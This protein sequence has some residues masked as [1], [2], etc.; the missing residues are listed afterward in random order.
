MMAP[1]PTRRSLLVSAASAGGALA[2]GAGVASLQAAESSPSGSGL[3]T[4]ASSLG[5]SFGCAVRLDQLNSDGDLRAAV[6]AQCGELT[7]EIG[8][9]WAVIEPR[10][11]ALDLAEM[12]DL[13]AFS[14]RHGLRLRGHTLLWHRS[15]P[16]WAQDLLRQSQDWN[17]ISRYFSSVMPRF[18]ASTDTWDVVNEPIE[19]GHRMDG[20]RESVFLDAFGP[21]YIPRALREARLF[22]PHAKLF[23]N[24]YDLEYDVPDQRARRYLLLKLLERL[25]TSGAP[26]D[27]LGLQSHLNLARGRVSQP[28]MRAFLTN[29]EDLGLLI[30]ISE[31]DVKEADYASS[32]QVRDQAVADETRRYLEIVLQA[33]RVTGV[34]TWG[35][36]DRYS[37]LE[38]TPSDLA[39]SP[40]AWRDGGG[41]GLNRGLPF[42]AAM[43]PKPMHQALRAALSRR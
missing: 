11:G 42:D 7:P 37:W 21:D 14:L 8:L 27:G 38:V 22:A 24:E 43:K 34:T 16:R 18:G 1:A 32:P 2:T 40:G 39:R 10:R 26:L 5:M 15:I 6:L 33:R 36:S 19:T 4:L 28:E 23:I 30:R 35:L 25:R 41:P 29:V 13:S 12:D 9:K 17:I 20:L 31:L 3:N